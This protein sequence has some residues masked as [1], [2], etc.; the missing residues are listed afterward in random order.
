MNAI[1]KGFQ[2]R[3]RAVIAERFGRATVYAYRNRPPGVPRPQVSE[4]TIK[5]WLR[6]EKPCMP[7]TDRLVV[8]AKEMGT[9]LDHLVFGGLPRPR[10]KALSVQVLEYYRRI[11]ADERRRQKHRDVER[12]LSELRALAE[13]TGRRPAA[14]RYAQTLDLIGRADDEVPKRG[15]PR[16]GAVGGDW[17]G[18]GV[19]GN[20][21]NV[22]AK[23]AEH[24]KA[25]EDE[26]KAGEPARRAEREAQRRRT[27]RSSNPDTGSATQ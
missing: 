20:A 14:R 10:G 25:Q 24:L 4:S 7:F 15:V 13:E 27:S 1:E 3:V 11:E 22:P 19:R 8:F 2:R 18:R 17:E 23:T 6:P 5:Q 16:G 12:L 9:T 26:L 21:R